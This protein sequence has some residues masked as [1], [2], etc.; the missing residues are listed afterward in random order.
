[1]KK[2]Y[3][4]LRKCAKVMLSIFLFLSTTSCLDDYLDKAPDVGLT[5]EEVFSNY[6][7]FKSYFYSV[8]Y[9]NGNDNDNFNIKCHFP[10]YF[11]LWDQKMTCESLTDMCDMSRIQYAQP[12]KRGIGADLFANQWGYYSNRKKVIFSWKAI[13]VCNT[14]IMNIDLV[15]DISTSDKDDMLAQAYF[16]KAFCHFELFR[17]YGSLPYIEKSLGQ[18]D[19]W[20]LPRLGAVE[21]LEK[22]AADFE[23]AAVYFEKAGKMRRDPASGQGSLNNPDQDKPNGVAAKAMRARALLYAASPLNNTSSQTKL[24]EDA[25]TAAWEAL[26]LALDNGY[27]LLP[28]D[29][30][31]NNLYGVKYTNEQIWAHSPGSFAYNKGELETFMA[32]VFSGAQNGSGQCPTQ[33]FVDRFETKDGYPLYSEDERLTAE[34]AGSYNEQKPFENRDP[35]MDISVIYNQKQLD[36]YGKASL[37]IEENG[38]K[39]AESLIS[40]SRHFSQTGY[41]ECKRTGSLASKSSV[42]TLLLTD[43]LIRLSELYLNYAEAANEAWGPDGKAP[44]AAM[45]ALEAL[46][47]VRGRANM[48]QVLSRFTD[49]TEALRP[50]IKNERIVEL[51]F[52]GFHYYCDIRRWKDAPEIM[53]GKLYGIQAVRLSAAN[54]N[55]TLYPTGFKYS[56]VELAADRQVSWRNAMYYVPF[57]KDDLIKMKNYVPNES[58]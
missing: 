45:T 21:M 7:N 12:P 52:E 3:S 15:K 29:K 10:L 38:S 37:Y 19:E 57:R 36:G 32:P 53:S 51:C 24:W 56:R 34:A 40:E 6:Q 5:R 2:I 9:G 22:I 30:Y 54:Q 4:K 25:A 47:V 18:D 46:N 27:A 48:P 17:F 31:T 55:A 16:V 26:N 41:Y 14:A 28:F 49:G 13:R 20:D 8:Y 43:P 39:P 42:K 1:M 58:W 44:G 11:H 35:R 23:T 33:N 50:R